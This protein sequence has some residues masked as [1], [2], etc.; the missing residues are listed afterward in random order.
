[1]ENLDKYE[2]LQTCTREMADNYCSKHK[3]S[4]EKEFLAAEKRLIETVEKLI[5]LPNNIT[6]QDILTIIYIVGCGLNRSNF[7]QVTRRKYATLVFETAVQI[8]EN[9]PV[10]NRSSPDSDEIMIMKIKFELAQIYS[11]NGQVKE[12]IQHYQHSLA[13]SIHY[14]DVANQKEILLCL[15]KSLMELKLYEEA[16]ISILILL[17]IKKDVFNALN[18]NLESLRVHWPVEIEHSVHFDL[19]VA[20]E[21]IGLLDKAIEEAN[22][23]KNLE[24][25]ITKNENNIKFF[26]ANSVLGHLEEKVGNF[27]QALL[28]YR[29]WLTEITEQ[30]GNTE[31]QKA[32]AL[33]FV[34][35]VLLK[36]NKHSDAQQCFQTIL[37]ISRN[38]TETWQIEAL[39]LL[40]ETELN[41]NL[42]E[43]C[44]LF[45][46]ALKLCQ[47]LR[48]ENLDL[49]VQCMLKDVA[50]FEKEQRFGHAL[51]QCECALSLAKKLGANQMVKKLELKVA[52][53]S[54]HST[55]EK[56]LLYA[57]SVLYTHI[58]EALTTKSN[59]QSDGIKTLA[60]EDVIMLDNCFK[61]LQVVL[62]RLGETKLSLAV[63]ECHKCQEYCQARNELPTLPK[64]NMKDLNITEPTEE[65]QVKILEANEILSP[66]AGVT[67]LNYTLLDTGFLLQ[68]CK[69]THVCMSYLLSDQVVNP[70]KVMLRLK[71]LVQNLQK[72]EKGS[73]SVNECTIYNTE[74]RSMPTNASE[75]TGKLNILLPKLDKSKKQQGAG[76]MPDEMVR[77]EKKQ[78]K[79][80]E[81]VVSDYILKEGKINEKSETVTKTTS[82]LDTL[83][84]LYSILIQPVSSVLSK[85]EDAAALC[86]V[87]ES[88]LFKIPFDEL[89]S[90]IDG[91]SLGEKFN[92][93]TIPCVSVLSPNDAQR[94]TKKTSRQK[95]TR[96][97]ELLKSYD[98]TKLHS[99]ELTGLD[100]DLMGLVT[101]SCTGTN[102]LT[103]PRYL[104]P[105]NQVCPNLKSCVMGCPVYTQALKLHNDVW[106]PK[107]RF[108]S[109]RNECKKVS[110][111]LDVTPVLENEATKQRFLEELTQST[112]LHV[113]TYGNLYD[114]VLAFSPNP[115]PVEI[116]PLPMSSYI[117]S[118]ED[119]YEIQ[120]TSVKLLVLSSIHKWQIEPNLKPFKLIN[121]LLY[122][123]IKCVVTNLWPVPD[124]VQETFYFNFYLELQ[125][126]CTVSRA[127]YAAKMSTKERYPD[128]VLWGA[129]GAFG[130]NVTIDLSEIRTA[131][132]Q[133]K[134]NDT[135]SNLLS[136]PNVVE[137]AKS[138][139][140]C[141]FELQ[142][143]ISRLSGHLSRDDDV[144]AFF[145]GIL[146]EAT[147]RLTA[148]D[149]SQRPIIL[150]PEPVAKT[151]GAAELLE[152]LGFNLQSVDL[153]SLPPSTRD[154]IGNDVSAKM[155]VFPHWN[156][157]GLLLPA[158]QALTGLHELRMSHC[159]LRSLATVLP[160]SQHM[161]CSLVDMLSVIH[162]SPKVQLRTNDV[163]LHD[164]WQVRT[165]RQFLRSIGIS[166]VR[167][168]VIFQRTI[169]NR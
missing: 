27:E 141:L 86:V 162:H 116:A 156:Q 97:N 158:H 112:V 81:N 54:Q 34:G 114:G 101:S 113:C 57:V 41:T 94:V 148:D 136:P 91:K 119:L 154:S 5:D 80:S 127:V 8:Y 152:R 143:L 123:G 124:K 58:T 92:V 109:G 151:N 155:L 39:L 126:K 14:N 9:A 147:E 133:R 75:K 35:Q 138:E 99:L 77:T 65:I 52:I 165:V 129:F 166:D 24:T 2:E 117:I 111:Y 85:L 50:V 46:Q 168:L 135:E 6:Q 137:E 18:G 140:T 68:V 16:T 71:D 79:F 21:N 47:N 69:D 108:G 3:N 33:K 107:C 78:V 7:N 139:K 72:R 60:F 142:S 40:G 13:I 59:L 130:N 157:D 125:S 104:T 15:S 90:T 49:E 4:H 12:S 37:Q 29:A 100:K 98:E 53:L 66:A 149:N 55:S 61:A 169:E 120:N 51:Y 167:K 76:D 48:H 74:N 63:S 131:Q 67:I 70:Q 89:V 153:T 96:R 161:L 163:S 11:S 56:E 150:L 32:Q 82:E 122:S 102:I 132:T 10:E 42:P 121:D 144:I 118:P 73:L 25:E 28:C 159:T 134:L 26:K 1:M 93:T 36:L 23:L 43:A 160:L 84:E 87:T 17:A 88:Y 20:Y 128:P 19:C 38:L 44:S 164:V 105:Y 64:L 31:E 95:C 103:S 146:E 106:Q 83:Q 30:N 115:F 110:Q 22:Q 45:K 62:Q 145:L